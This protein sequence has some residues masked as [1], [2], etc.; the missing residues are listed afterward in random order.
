MYV[1]I[2]GDGP[3]KNNLQCIV[4][5][6]EISKYFFFYGFLDEKKVANVFSRC[7]LGYAVFPDY[8]DN[9]SLNAEPGKV[10][11]YYIY[12]LPVVIT[13]NIYLSKLIKKYNCGF[14]IRPNQRSINELLKKNLKSMCR[15]ISLN[16]NNFYQNECL[17]TKHFDK[18]FEAKNF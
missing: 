17:A 5:K 16:I 11:C 4:K 10:K 9:H 2:I 7:D 8:A 6:K 1:H 12:K 14:V 18:F 15:K 13:N 3:F